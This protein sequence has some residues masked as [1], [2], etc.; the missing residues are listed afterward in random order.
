MFNR[1]RKEI[2][3]ELNENLLENENN[4]LAN[5]FLNSISKYFGISYNKEEIKTVIIDILKTNQS[6]LTRV[7]KL[8]KLDRKHPKDNKDK[9]EIDFLINSLK[10]SINKTLQQKNIEIPIENE[11]NFLGSISS[12]FKEEELQE[13]MLL[14]TEDEKAIK[15]ELQKA[16]DFFGGKKVEGVDTNRFIRL[17]NMIRDNLKMEFQV[18]FKLLNPLN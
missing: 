5:W 17:G 6:F 4:L 15:P 12:I 18:I 3:T 16:M 14:L 13:A 2:K 7:L 8:K 9:D 1:L 10:L 11:K